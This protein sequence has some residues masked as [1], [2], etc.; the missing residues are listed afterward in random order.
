MKKLFLVFFIIG[1]TGCETPT[2]FSEEAVQEKF[3]NW[4]E[5][6]VTFQEVLHQYR[7]KKVLIDVWASWCKDC[8]VGLP[9]LKRVQEEHP[10][11]NYVFLSLDRNIQSWKNGVNRFQ[12]SGEHY[13][14][15]A[16]KKGAF[17]DF[18]N[19]WWIPRYVVLNEQGE[20]VLFKAI[21]ITDKN[22]TEALKK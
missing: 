3:L 6:E 9:D 10:N 5:E 1:F 19:L 20:I 12:I 21:K 7:G 18:L 8:I 15:K 4:E 13:F 22:I 17:G 11:V 2:Q 14:M 16:G